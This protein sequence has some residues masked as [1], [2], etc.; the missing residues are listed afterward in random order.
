LSAKACRLDLSLEI[1]HQAHHA[2]SIDCEASARDVRIACG[3]VLGQRAQL[4]AEL[5]TFQI[6]YHPLRIFGSEDRVGDRLCDS[7][8]IRVYSDA[9]HTRTAETTIS[10]AGV[11]R[12][13]AREQKAQRHE[14]TQQP[15]GSAAAKP[16]DYAMSCCKHSI[17]LGC[18][19][20]VA[21]VFPF[22]S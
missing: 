17:P 21:H 8:V 11:C 14:R 6:D 18:A 15:C 16:I 5:D 2:W 7:S 9:G 4:L 1:E 20:Q 13:T 22:P 3:D 12:Q 19:Q 10:S